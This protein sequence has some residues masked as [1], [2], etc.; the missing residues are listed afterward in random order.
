MFPTPFL[1]QWWVFLF[2]KQIYIAWNWD[3]YLVRKIRGFGCETYEEEETTQ[4]LSRIP[5]FQKNLVR[6]S[7]FTKVN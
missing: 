7:K 2:Q 6:N 3:Q 1:N 5:N 4:A